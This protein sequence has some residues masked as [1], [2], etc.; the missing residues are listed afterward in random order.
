MTAAY[1]S[2]NATN[3]AKRGRRL[4]DIYLTT[5]FCLVEQS[6]N[7]RRV[8]PAS[9]DSTETD[10]LTPNHFLL[11]TAD[12]SLTSYFNYHFN[13]CKR[14]VR[15]QP[16][17][18]ARWNK[19]LKKYVPTLNRRAKLSTQYSRKLKT[20]DLDSFLEITSPRGYYPL[21]GTLTVPVRR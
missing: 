19:W 13:N 12:S 6:V 4:T 16:Y 8:I 2:R 10:A 17:S 18:D 20:G 11:G 5:V 9:A 21:T 14:Y 15:A 7:A 3:Y 1:G